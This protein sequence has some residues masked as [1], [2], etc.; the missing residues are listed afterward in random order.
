MASH[1][2]AHISHNPQADAQAAG[3]LPNTALKTFKDLGLL[4]ASNA[5]TVVANSHAGK[6]VI[7]V[8]LDFDRTTGS[9]SDRI[10]YEIADDLLDAKTIPRA[11]RCATRRQGER[12]PGDGE[13]RVERVNDFADDLCE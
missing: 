5:D 9:E 13:L 3:T 4:F 8:H 6:I 10:R 11:G 2:G 7:G 12:A 1:R